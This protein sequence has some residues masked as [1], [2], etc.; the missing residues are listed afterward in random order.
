MSASSAFAGIRSAEPD[1]VVDVHFPNF[2]A[3]HPAARR[4]LD[5]TIPGMY[6]PSADD[7]AGRAKP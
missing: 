2:A 3:E 7:I 1:S 4:L 6:G 5:V